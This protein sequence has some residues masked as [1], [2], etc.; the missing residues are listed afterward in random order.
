M[1]GG[2]ILRGL[3]TVLSAGID[4]GTSTTKL[5]ISRLFIQNTAGQTQVPRIEIIG[6]EVI[7]KS[8]IFRTPLLDEVTIDVQAVEKLV[9]EQ[10]RLAQVSVQ[11]IQTG[12]ILITGET[13]TKSN[14]S[15]VIHSLSN[16]A[17]DF[18]VATA[19]P[20]LESILAAHGSGAMGCSK[21]QIKL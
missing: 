5:I 14:A 8:P 4:I 20:D 18:L 15:E 16:V 12:A 3:Q 6:Q 21:V 13:A 1:L 10:Y 2:G 7:Y 11:Q 9:F 19:G 17:G